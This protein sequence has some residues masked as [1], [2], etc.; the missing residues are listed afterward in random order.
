MKV[1]TPFLIVGISFGVLLV[2]RSRLALLGQA[3]ARVVP[4]V[5][6]GPVT[7]RVDE[8]RGL[9]WTV[10][11]FRRAAEDDDL[12]IGERLGAAELYWLALALRRD[13]LGQ[14]TFDEPFELLLALADALPEEPA[15]AGLAADALRAHR[16]V[17]G[18][19]GDPD[20]ALREGMLAREVV[21]LLTRID[22]DNG[23]F[24]LLAAEI[25]LAD[26][27][28][29]EARQS[30]VL[31]ARAPVV[32]SRLRHRSAS[33][34]A[35]LSSRGLPD[36]ETCEFLLDDAYED[37][38]YSSGELLE[39]IADRIGRADAGRLGGEDKHRWMETFLSLH[40]CAERLAEAAL[41][42]TDARQALAA[43]NVYLD[44][45]R[46]APTVTARDVPRVGEG[47]RGVKAMAER[48]AA[49]G[50]THGASGLED[51][52]RGESG[53]LRSHVNARTRSRRVGELVLPLSAA[54]GILVRW[55]LLAWVTGL[56]L[57]PW[58][59]RRRK[60]DGDAAPAESAA[61][62][63]RVER[64]ERTGRP[65]RS[66][67]RRDPSAAWTLPGLDF[68]AAVAPFALLVWIGHDGIFPLERP[69][70]RS[71]WIAMF[72]GPPLFVVLLPLLS[73]AVL[74]IPHLLIASQ[75]NLRAYATRA[76]G[77]FLVFGCLFF[78]GF[79]VTTPILGK[80]RGI[81]Q[82]ELAAHV[83]NPGPEVGVP[84]W[85]A[86]PTDEE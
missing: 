66:R 25:A 26:E 77:F 70:R 56:L 44:A 68:L 12:P 31:A 10:E 52:V 30:L 18:P 78:L 32:D 16:E 28:I 21:R 13:A 63:R 60:E 1:W 80:L 49:A 9:S 72:G 6:A 74:A 75:R 4:S 58:V 73:A 54:H 41:L 42:K 35:F 83:S 69:I 57:L 27:R 14:E 38:N 71:E 7:Y 2:D 34:H 61:A 11:E 5:D 37:R 43:P 40:Q 46:A 23:Y 29:E 15:F 50:Y 24:D 45:L 39:R 85:P 20:V 84:I 86:P 79:A 33:A 81:R 64:S 22:P 55:A 59:R 3:A 8:P 48:L 53:A 65:I 62:A 51:S 82:A 76:S 17:V 36:L 19:A 47:T 67:R